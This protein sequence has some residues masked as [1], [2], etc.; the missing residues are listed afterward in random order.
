MRRAIF[1]SHVVPLKIE[2]SQHD[3]R[4]R[5]SIR[6]KKNEFDM[7]CRESLRTLDSLE[8]VSAKV[9]C[10]ATRRAPPEM[11]G[12]GPPDITDHKAR[13]RRRGEKRTRLSRVWPSPC[14]TESVWSTTFRPIFLP[15]YFQPALGDSNRPS[16]GEKSTAE[17]RVST[18]PFHRRRPAA[19]LFV[20]CPFLPPNT[21]TAIL[22]SFYAHVFLLL[23]CNSSTRSVGVLTMG[24]SLVLPLSFGR[25]REISKWFFGTCRTDIEHLSLRNIV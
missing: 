9:V 22:F 6:E 3:V 18:S 23:S 1:V 16:P 8:G 24:P 2:M 12:D 17:V 10:I 19:V 14:R 4:T 11:Y 13:R 25:E 7:E 15:S 5:G 20:S 21:C